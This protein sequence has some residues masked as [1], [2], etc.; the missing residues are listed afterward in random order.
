MLIF[1]F[2]LANP[3]HAIQVL[4]LCSILDSVDNLHIIL[5]PWKMCSI[6]FILSFDY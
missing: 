5:D 1:F 2:Y 4:C 3:V 6:E